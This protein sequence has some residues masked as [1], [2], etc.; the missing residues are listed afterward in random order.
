M[1]KIIFSVFFLF[2][3]SQVFGQQSIETNLSS[4]NSV[5][6][7]LMGSGALYS[8]NFDRVVFSKKSFGI[9]ARVGITYTPFIEDFNDYP[10]IGFPF[11]LTGLIGRKNGKFEFGIGGAYHYLFD[12]PSNYSFLFFV[13]RI[14][15]RLQKDQG[16]L[17]IKTGFTPWIPIAID[18][19]FS[20]DKLEPSFFPMIG[21]AIGYTFKD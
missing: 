7:E 16:G 10:S 3:T 5:Y 17:F 9:S 8:F 13:P 18:D 2:L 19:N 12:E 14:G 6:V 11:E 4:K 20:E 1:N 21:F 15:Y